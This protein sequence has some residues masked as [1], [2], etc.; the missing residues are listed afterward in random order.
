VTGLTEKHARALC[1]SLK[2]KSQGCVLTRR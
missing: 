2:A 1:K